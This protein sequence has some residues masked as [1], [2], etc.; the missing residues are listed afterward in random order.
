M[1]L[2]ERVN[3]MKMTL[4]PK[5]IY[6]FNAIPI[7]LPMAFFTELEQKFTIHME[8]QKTLNSQS[9]LEKEKRSWRNQS[10][11]LQTIPQKLQKS[12]HYGTGT[13]RKIEIN[14]TGQKAQR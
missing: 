5:A 3:T 4:L 1:F 2:V 14:G 6:R 10:P 7:K 12:Q 8:T 9:K 11:R 13:K